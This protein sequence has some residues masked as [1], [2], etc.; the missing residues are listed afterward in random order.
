M[1]DNS[2][3][4]KK[5]KLKKFFLNLY[6]PAIVPGNNLRENEHITLFKSNKNNVKTEHYKNIDDTVEA[7]LKPQNH[8]YNVYFNLATTNGLGRDREAQK[9]RYC[10]AFDFDKKDLGEQCNIYYIQE[11][12]KK[13]SLYYHAIVDS[14]N[15]YHF[16]IFIEPTKNIDLVEK[17][18]KILA[19]RLGADINATLS[20]QL[21][22][23]PCTFNIKKERKK[24]NLVHIDE[25]PKRKSIEYFNRQYLQE[26][27]LEG[28]GNNYI[29]NNTNIPPCMLKIIADGSNEGNRHNDLYKLVKTLQNRNKTEPQILEVLK[30]WNNKSNP[31]LS[32]NDLKNSIKGALKSIAGILYSCNGCASSKECFNTVYSDFNHT[33]FD[34]LIT[35]TESHTKYLKSSN[36]KGA[37]IMTGNDLLVYG[38]LKNHSDGLYRE[39]IE[40]VLTYKKT[41]ALSKPTLTK[42][43]QSLEENKFITVEKIGKRKFY[44]LNTVRSKEEC[45]YSVSIGA[46]YNTIRG[47][48]ST[49]ELR[50]YNYMRYLHHKEQRENPK[51]LKG[52]LF[53]I[54]QDVLAKDL[55][56]TQGRISQMVQ[57][58]IDERLIDIWYRQPSKN[59][60]F[61]YNIYR[62]NY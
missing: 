42:T 60:G 27:P 8:Y 11:Q 51:A 49:E 62:L 32:E 19:N 5:Y 38:I 28:E 21:L 31:P 17:V 10:L 2:Q 34:N 37:K 50:L 6:R 36:R 22:R 29:V 1:S 12:F 58:L 43:L 3:L 41:V 59:N 26:K 52:N 9:V 18:N 30:S 23:V 56:V 15:G 7:I 44:K 54:N 40:E 25:N 61:L 53:Q 47:I 57:N 45:K 20:T 4:D 33:E 35:L 14:G 46:T 55:G 48:I 24:V 39:E 13:N 16:Y